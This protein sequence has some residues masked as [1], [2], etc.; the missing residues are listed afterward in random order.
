VWKIQKWNESEERRRLN[1]VNPQ[2]LEENSEQHS[3]WWERERERERVLV[4]VWIKRR[5]DYYDLWDEMRW[6]EK[7]RER[8]ERNEMELKWSSGNSTTNPHKTPFTLV[9]QSYVFVYF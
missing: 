7:W 9:L 6:D 8:G 2:T 1:W 5:N 4:F 3:L